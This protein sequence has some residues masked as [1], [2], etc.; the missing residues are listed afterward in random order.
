MTNDENVPETMKIIEEHAKEIE[1]FNKKK[2]KKFPITDSSWIEE[3]LN[4]RER[5][6]KY[7][8]Y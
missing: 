1:R 4:E 3:W 7:G 5:Q 2:K 6:K 8:F